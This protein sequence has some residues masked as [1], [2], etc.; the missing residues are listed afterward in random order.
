MKKSLILLLCL[1]IVLSGCGKRV[2]REIVS[3]NGKL[4]AQAVVKEDT[5]EN[6]LLNLSKEWSLV[7]SLDAVES[8][9]EA[10]VYKS[11]APSYK[12]AKNLSNVKNIKQFSGFSK[13]QISMLSKNGFVVIPS[14]H[15][16]S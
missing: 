3:D 16:F 12:I 6:K 9:Y 11:N 7:Q 13:Q 2:K 8:K 5:L 15:K 1:C 4:T 14:I 10:P